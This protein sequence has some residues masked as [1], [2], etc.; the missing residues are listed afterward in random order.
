MKDQDSQEKSKKQSSR[1]KAKDKVKDSST[2]D[3]VVLP[4]N[5]DIG[6]ISQLYQEIISVYTNHNL[7][8]DASK[9]QNITT[10][11]VQLLIAATNTAKARNIKITIPQYSEMFKNT[12]TIMGFSNQFKEWVDA[13]V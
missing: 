10:P 5:T 7:A 13:N 6:S 9:V 3:V 8:I 11:G 1:R 4:A 12:L 2:S